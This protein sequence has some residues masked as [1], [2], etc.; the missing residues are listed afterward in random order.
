MTTQDEEL[1]ALWSKTSDRGEYLTGTINGVRVICFRERE[2]R[3]P[4]GPDWRVLKARERPATP[5]PP[6]DDDIG[7]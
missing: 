3:N 5:P 7:L 6:Q 4:K 2:K 1:G